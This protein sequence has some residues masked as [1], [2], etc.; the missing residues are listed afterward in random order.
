MRVGCEKVM[1]NIYLQM[2]EKLFLF[3]RSLQ[4]LVSQ[5]MTGKLFLPTPVVHSSIKCL[6]EGFVLV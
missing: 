2:L 3:K 1:N 4:K 5:L 6:S